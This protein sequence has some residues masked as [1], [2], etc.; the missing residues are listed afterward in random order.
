MKSKLA[1]KEVKYFGHIVNKQGIHVEV[2]AFLGMSQFYRRY[3]KL[4]V[5]IA[6]SLNKLLRKDTKLCDMKNLMKT[7]L[8]DK[9][10]I[11]LF[12]F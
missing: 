1:A 10:Q 6:L 11:S 2:R 4:F 8:Y 7:D 3:I 9:T 12:Y 5:Q